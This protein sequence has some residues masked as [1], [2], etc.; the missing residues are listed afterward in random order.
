[1]CD[2]NEGL[3]RPVISAVFYRT[4][5]TLTCDDDSP[6]IAEPT[7]SSGSDRSVVMIESVVGEKTSS[8]R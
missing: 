6:D 3:N 8:L 7:L 4:R 5:S 1:M 2:F